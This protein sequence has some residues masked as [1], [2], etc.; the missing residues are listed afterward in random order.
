[1]LAQ[2]RL[3]HGVQLPGGAQGRRPDPRPAL[4]RAQRRGRRGLRPGVR[5]QPRRGGRSL[6]VPGPQRPGDL[7]GWSHV[8]YLR[9]RDCRRR[10]AGLSLASALA[11]QCSVALVEAEQTLAYHTSARSA[12]QL[13]PSYG[14]PVVQELTVRT[15]DLIAAEDAERP[16][17]VLAAAQLHADRRRR[18]RP[19]GSQRPHATDHP[20]RGPAAC[21][22]PW[23]RNPSAPPAWTPGPSPAT[24][25]CC[26]RTTGSAPRPA[27]WTSSPAPGSTRPSASAP[28]GNSA[29]GRKASRPPSWSMRPAPGRT[30]SPSSAA[31]RSSA[32][33]RTGAPRRSSTS[34]I[35]SR[36]P[37]RWWRRPTTASTSGRDDGQVLIS[38][39][40]H[41]PSGPEDARPYPGDVER[42]HRPAQHDHHPRDPRRPQGLDGAAD[43]SGR[44]RPGGG[45]RRRGHRI[46]LARRPGRLRLPDL[47]RHRR[48][49]RRTDPR[50]AGRR[51]PGPRRPTQASPAS[52][53]AEALA[54]TR[55]SIRR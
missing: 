30:N 54:A 37:A 42:A 44:R 12:R 53:T 31:S 11:G 34:T 25:P 26:W 46:L 22:R 38:P 49:R 5:P 51:R 19:G 41:V 32:C 35:P 43:G 24:P 3:R 14:P 13:I 33:S 15:L 18:H 2:R 52:R 47:L 27:A 20:R 36:R 16:E 40:E 9:C 8:S 7:Q 21:A 55:W 39:S 29:P 23:C 17:P 50:R 4:R 1:M 45:V 48:T 6:T 28:A 10:I